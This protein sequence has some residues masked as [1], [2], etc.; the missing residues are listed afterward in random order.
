[1]LELVLDNVDLLGLILSYLSTSDIVRIQRTCKFWLKIGRERKVIE[2]PDKMKVRLRNIIYSF[3]SVTHIVGRIYKNISENIP[4]TLHSVTFYLDNHVPSLLEL[5]TEHGNKIDMT[6]ISISGKCVINSSYLRIDWLQGINTNEL[7]AII[8]EHN[9]HFGK[10]SLEI[11]HDLIIDQSEDVIS[12][13]NVLYV[14]FRIIPGKDDYFSSI[15][16]YLNF[17]KQNKLNTVI[18]CLSIKFL[19]SR[20]VKA[21][22]LFLHTNTC[23]GNFK[24]SKINDDTG[25]SINYGVSMLRN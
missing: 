5:F 7:E 4:L 6:F 19:T 21:I 11:F 25:R 13:L 23:N 9:K 12:L 10:V 24:L 3:P 17:L 8:K 1:M 18:F 22:H 15:R 20:Y 16:R 14:K 2:I